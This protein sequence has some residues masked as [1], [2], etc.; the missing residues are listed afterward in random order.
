MRIVFYYPLTARI[1]HHLKEFIKFKSQ[2][3]YRKYH[4]FIPHLFNHS[5]RETAI[6]LGV[7]SRRRTYRQVKCLAWEIINRIHFWKVKR[8]NRLEELD[9]KRDVLLIFPFLS[10]GY[11]ALIQDPVVRNY[12]GLKVF[13]FSHYFDQPEKMCPLIRTLPHTLIIGE[14]QLD[15]NA[16]YKKFMGEQPFYLLP[17]A[18]RERYRSFTPFQSRKAK[19]FAFGTKS[20]T[21]NMYHKA[22]NE[23][24]QAN[25]LH[26]LRE[27]IYYKREEVK[28]EIDN[29]I[30]DWEEWRDHRPKNRYEKFKRALEKYI[31]N[32]RKRFFSFDIVQKYNE[33]Q[34]FV[35][36]EEES[37]APPIS[38][39]EGMACGCAYF[40]RPEFYTGY[41]MVAGEHFVGYDG[42]LDDLVKQI[43]YYQEHPDLLEQIAHRGE[44]F[45]KNHFQPK[46]VADNF[47]QFLESHLQSL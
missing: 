18:L 6:F 7:Q 10:L 21:N 3:A 32:E 36:P 22:F 9:P 25:Y 31:G 33:Y 8:V 24:F 12:T 29:F 45:V 46:K 47:W 28:E 44:Q 40:G 11:E 2:H 16:L 38:F 13:H 17:F 19:C 34:T 15:Q 43:R 26:K 14:G 23:T 5:E 1:G 27:E 30:F 39:M 41:Q 4:Y 35:S 37:G 42:T 20:R